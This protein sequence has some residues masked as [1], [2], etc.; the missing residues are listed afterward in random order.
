LPWAEQGV[1]HPSS[2]QT[3]WFQGT[4]LDVPNHR[5]MVSLVP[6]NLSSL[7]VVTITDHSPFAC[8]AV[9]HWTPTI[10]LRNPDPGK[11]SPVRAW[12]TDR[13]W[14]IGV[15]ID[16]RHASRGLIAA[17]DLQATTRLACNGHRLPEPD[18][19]FQS[20]KQPAI[21]LAPEPFGGMGGVVSSSAN[22]SRIM[23]GWRLK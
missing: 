2:E 18:L 4:R 1:I 16:L 19:A 15:L 6:I 7:S 8:P 21:A 20:G 12:A 3:A 13:F 10:G 9:M 14:R 11:G 5:A 22:D 23:A 17:Q